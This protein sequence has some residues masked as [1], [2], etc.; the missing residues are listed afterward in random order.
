MITIKTSLTVKRS[1]KR[2]VV[3]VKEETRMILSRRER[4]H[5]QRTNRQKIRKEN[6]SDR[7]RSRL[8]ITK[9]EL[10]NNC[11]PIR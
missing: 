10:T 6:H 5:F 11:G 4:A 8:S 3:G 1:E 2:K 7:G 9:K